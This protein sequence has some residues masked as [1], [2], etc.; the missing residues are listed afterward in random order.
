M[1]TLGFVFGI[2]GLLAYLQTSSLKSRIADLER[3]MRQI[4]GTDYAETKK[5]LAEAA[6]GYVGQ[7]IQLGFKED[8]EDPDVLVSNMKAGMCKLMDADEDWLLVRVTHH[9]AVREK[10]IRIDSIKSISIR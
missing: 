5:S 7:N 8:E 2:F 6:K 10:L 3:Q 1:G 4:E 9:G